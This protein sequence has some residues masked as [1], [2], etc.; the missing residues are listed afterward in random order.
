MTMKII[1]IR[2]AFWV[3]RDQWP[4]LGTWLV[5]HSNEAFV[6]KQVRDLTKRLGESEPQ[7]FLDGT[8]LSEMYVGRVMFQREEF[9]SDLVVKPQVMAVLWSLQDFL[10]E[11]RLDEGFLN[12]CSTEQQ[13]ALTS[14]FVPYLQALLGEYI[15]S[16][17]EYV[18]AVHLHVD[19]E[20][21]GVKEDS[22]I[23]PY[24]DRQ[25]RAGA[26]YADIYWSSKEPSALFLWTPQT[27]SQP[28]HIL[29]SSSAD[30]L[31][32]LMGE[33]EH[34][35]WHEILRRVIGREIDVARSEARGALTLRDDLGRLAARRLS[36]LSLLSRFYTPP[37]DLS[38]ELG[39]SIV[40]LNEAVQRLQ[41]RRANLRQIR[42]MYEEDLLWRGDSLILF[43]TTFARGR[44]VRITEADI[45]KLSLGLYLR[46]SGLQILEFY[47]QRIDETCDRLKGLLDSY[48]T[49]LDV[50]ST[51]QSD[52]LNSLVLL[53]TILSA[54]L[55]ILQV[56]SAFDFWI[57]EG[58]LYIL[59]GAVLVVVLL[60]LGLARARARRQQS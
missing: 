20:L 1:E 15:S 39:R 5:A 37:S 11:F 6:E 26:S 33:V 36:V 31:R 53:L 4:E 51:Q 45:G 17:P 54:F 9:L 23:V 40:N 42:M 19:D 55:A 14:G 57:E 59:A 3:Q 47:D 38:P 12:G 32:L 30:V 41:D 2:G 56:L 46:R 27:L 49:L 35:V 18:A 8:T 24:L 60:F 52:L 43:Q 50:K 7:V 22:E 13:D 21:V 48:Q 34:L 44:L 28:A 29:I 10:L 25:F 16:P 58:R